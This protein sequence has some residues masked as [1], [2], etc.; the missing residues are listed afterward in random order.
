MLCLIKFLFAVVKYLLHFEPRHG[1]YKPIM[2]DV[3][4]PDGENSEQSKS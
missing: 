2:A 4:K 1:R 3:S